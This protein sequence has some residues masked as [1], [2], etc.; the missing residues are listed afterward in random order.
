MVG[1]SEFL[2]ASK[3]KYDSY[4]S[5][6]WIKSG[7]DEFSGGYKVY[8]K[9]HHF[10]PTIGKFNIPR[11]D[12]EKNASEIL[13]KYGMSVELRSEKQGYGVKTPDGLLDNV[14]F[15]IKG[16]EGNSRRTIKDAI[17]K[18]SKQGAEIAVLYFHDKNMFDV[19][20]VRESYEKYLADSKSKKIRTVYCVAGER[21][22][23]I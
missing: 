14:L 16:I 10:D 5:E 22:Y 6:D 20:F 7:F 13:V 17:S 2:K 15:D 1:R 12:Y 8:H 23:R 19:D 4:C 9:N 11:G 18:S 3:S 21:L